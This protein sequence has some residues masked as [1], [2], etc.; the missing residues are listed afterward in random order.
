MI[1]TYSG[2]DDI[3]SDY[4][5]E[6]IPSEHN[7]FCNSTENS[8]YAE[9]Y[10]KVLPAFF[11]RTERC[12]R[13][14]YSYEKKQLRHYYNMTGIILAAKLFIEIAACFFFYILMF[15][16]AYSVSPSM[17]MYYSA[18][19]DTTVK[20]AF[21][22]IAITLSTAS[23][24]FAGCRF[25]SFPP[26]KL[27]KKCGPVK[28]ADVIISF[29]TGMFIAALQNIITL[30]NPHL[31]GEFGFAGVP[32][33][34]DI[35]MI[36]VVVLYTCIVVP[37][38]EG[39]IFRGIALK[40]FSRASQRF[41]ILASS[42]FCALSTCSFTA[43]FPAFLMSVLLSKMTVKYNTVIPS[44]LI[45]ITVNLSGMIISVYGALAWNS[46]L[47]IMKIW[48]VITL[49]LGG[50]SAFAMLFRHPLPKI[51]PEQRRRTLPVLMTS[52]FPVLLIPLYI[53]TSV[54]KVLYFMY[55]H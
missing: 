23:V 53:L 36:T 1:S 6:E 18:L 38:S 47:L 17:S 9:S 21:R 7:P 49:V 37:V 11:F 52:V 40:N 2:T 10:S 8:Q 12:G 41:G 34:R 32:L 13:K 43:M 27:M 29:M 33:S 14:P 16:C 55:M 22:I 30:S 39:L 54:L 35:R 3:F 4:D 48:T 46:D 26:Q 24:F 28:T 15:L 19:S 45:H 42:F 5:A 25:S 50:L 44:I 31:N 51:K 20:Y